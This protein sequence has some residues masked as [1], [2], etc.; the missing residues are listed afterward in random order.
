MN[1]FSFKDN[2]KYFSLPMS[3]LKALI[4]K[5]NLC[6]IETFFTQLNFRMDSQQYKDASC[7][8]FFSLKPMTVHIILDNYSHF[9]KTQGF[10]Y[11]NFLNIDTNKSQQLKFYGVPTIEFLNSILNTIRTLWS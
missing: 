5:D 11:I 9:N 8:L 2:K 3:D 10:T 6:F 1:F 7:H 4:R